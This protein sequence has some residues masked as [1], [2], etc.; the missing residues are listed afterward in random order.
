MAIIGAHPTLRTMITD[1]MDFVSKTRIRQSVG[2]VIVH[3]VSFRLS[4]K[5][6]NIIR[7][8]LS[9]TFDL[10]ELLENVFL[11]TFMKSF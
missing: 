9:F 8:W 11:L 5:A 4:F 6:M 7:N 2:M 10:R 1:G 3:H